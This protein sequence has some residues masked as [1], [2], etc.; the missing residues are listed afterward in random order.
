MQHVVCEFFDKFLET[1]YQ[2]IPS[3]PFTFTINSE[4]SHKGQP[5]DKQEVI[6][7]SIDY[8]LCL[9]VHRKKRNIQTLIDDNCQ[10][11]LAQNNLL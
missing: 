5:C 6:P 11:Q 7:N 2:D 9:P 8:F 4:L 10:P 1:L 3:L